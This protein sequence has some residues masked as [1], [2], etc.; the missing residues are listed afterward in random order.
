MIVGNEVAKVAEDGVRCTFQNKCYD[1]RIGETTFSV[2]D[3][4]GLNEGERDRA[5]NWKA[6][7]GLYTLLRQLNG[8]SLLVYCMRGKLTESSRGNWMLFNKVICDEKVP[9]IAVV[10]GLEHAEALEHEAAKAKSHF[11]T[12]GMRPKEL[13]CI[14]SIQ[15]KHNEFEELYNHSQ[16]MLQKLVAESCS[17]RKWSTETEDWFGRIYQNVYTTRICFLP[18]VQVQF[19]DAV[20]NVVDQFIKESN[21]EAD[22][23]RRLKDTLLR[24]EKKLLKKRRSLW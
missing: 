4:C 10:T 9:I 12:S 8:V 18:R 2:Y 1:A 19:I 20:G 21:M 7:E 16:Q 6:V 22:E 11:E 3:T 23:A 13:C 24:A 15:G 5:L 17:R 14:V